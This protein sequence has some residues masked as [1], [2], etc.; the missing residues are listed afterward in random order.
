MK[1]LFSLALLFSMLMASTG[2]AQLRALKKPDD[3]PDKGVRKEAKLLAKA[4]LKAGNS[5]EYFEVGDGDGVLVVGSGPEEDQDDEEIKKLKEA[6]DPVAGFEKVKGKGKAPKKLVE[7]WDRVQAKKAAAPPD[8]ENPPPPENFDPFED[9]ALT[10]EEDG[11]NRRQL[12][13]WCP[14]WYYQTGNRYAYKWGSYIRGDITYVHYGC[15]N[16]ELWYWYSPYWY[17]TGYRYGACTGGYAWAYYYH[18]QNNYLLGQ[19]TYAYGDRYDWGV[20]INS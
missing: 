10:E 8:D 3:K 14:W 13:W 1:F 20:C 19:T 18:W 6:E 11:G 7:A 16:I 9:S 4:D 2:E 12:G 15:L 17:Y 5:V